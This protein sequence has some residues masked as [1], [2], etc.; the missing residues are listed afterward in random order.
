[1]STYRDYLGTNPVNGETW[2]PIS[3]GKMN[4]SAVRTCLDQWIA[5]GATVLVPIVDIFHADTGGGNNAW[6][7]I[8]GVAAFVLTAR[9]QPAVDQIQG[10]FVEYYPYTDIPGNIGSVPPDPGDIT[11]FIG[12]VK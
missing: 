3:T 11:V 2:F 6:Y 9:E 10:R 7:H 1:V 8:T 5:S 4:T 12:L